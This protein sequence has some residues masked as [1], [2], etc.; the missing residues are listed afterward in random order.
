MNR[1][2]VSII[3][4]VFNGANH[5]EE[6][7][8]HVL[9]QTYPNIEYIIIDGGSTDGTV[10]IIKKYE[11]R[12]A[13]WTSRPDK[14]L[15]YAMN[16]GLKQAR[17]QIIGLINADDFYDVNA[18]EEVVK[19]FSANDVDV[20]CTDVIILKER[21][22]MVSTAIGVADI[23]GMEKKMSVWHPGCFVKKSAYDHEGLF[24]TSYRIT[25]DYDLLIRFLK[26]GMKFGHLNKPLVKFR[27][28]GLAGRSL[29]RHLECYRIASK[30]HLSGKN[31]HLRNYIFYSF[32]LP[33]VSFIFS[34]AK[35]FGL[36]SFLEK[37]NVRK[38]EG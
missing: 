27:Y 30:Y 37:R 19:F 26:S 33:F 35:F 12:L 9:G 8:T 16:D 29:K 28:G 3:T 24:D 6:T 38:W 4:V 1:P 22:N 34:V 20:C 17:G 15:Y 18:V 14:G 21:E 10:D 7:I 25:A 23:N 11:L 2:L 13:Y 32:Y 36:K 31:Q 5:I